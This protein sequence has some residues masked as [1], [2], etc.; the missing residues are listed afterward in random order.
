MQRRSL[1]HA[2][3]GIILLQRKFRQRRLDKEQKRAKEKQQEQDKL[4][5]EQ[6]RINK[7]QKKMRK[8]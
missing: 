1:K 7:I 3:W 6:K 5:L 4:V 2:E 8:K